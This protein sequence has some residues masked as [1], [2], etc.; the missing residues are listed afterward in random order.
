MKHISIYGKNLLERQFWIIINHRRVRVSIIMDIDFFELF[1]EQF[2]NGTLRS[3]VSKFG[4]QPKTLNMLWIAYGQ[5]LSDPKCLL[6]SLNFMMSNVTFDALH[7]DWGCAYDTFYN[8]IWTAIDTLF[9]RMKLIDFVKRL[10]FEPIKVVIRE[11]PQSDYE[12]FRIFSII[13][14]TECPVSRPK[15]D[16][17]QRFLYSGYKKKHTLKYNVICCVMNDYI[18]HVSGP[19]EGKKNDLVAIEETGI[20]DH[21][22]EDVGYIRLTFRKESWVTLDTEEIPHL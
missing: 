1:K 11:S 15:D 16:V 6:W 20:F 13:D 5:F 9:A 3:F 14:A 10:E 7:S 4:M 2:P 18:L 17:Y 19:Y 8:T 21:L 12:A 22:Q